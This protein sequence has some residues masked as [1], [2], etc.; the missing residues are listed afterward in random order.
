MSG[1]VITN[2]TNKEKEP[3]DY[4]NNPQYHKFAIGS[5]MSTLVPFY[6]ELLE[7]V[8]GEKVNETFH[9]YALS[10]SET[11]A[12]QTLF[13]QQIDENLFFIEPLD[14]RR[15]KDWSFEWKG[16]T[17]DLNLS[18]ISPVNR[19]IKDFNSIVTICRECLFF[20]KPMYLSIE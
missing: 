18:L 14:K 20:N 15:Y 4:Y 8:I 7:E 5:G 10:K 12:I 9:D 6:K 13:E 2:V 3:L 11:Q 16:K 19:N 17:Y 1:I